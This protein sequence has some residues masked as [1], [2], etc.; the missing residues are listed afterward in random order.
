[1]PPTRM[2]TPESA[3]AG[4]CMRVQAGIEKPGGLHHHRK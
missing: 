3:G 2:Q 1:M 4:R